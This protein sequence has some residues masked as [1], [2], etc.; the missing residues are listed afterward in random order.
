MYVLGITRC[1]MLRHGREATFI[2][3]LHLSDLRYVPAKT[4]PVCEGLETHEDDE[5]HG[6]QAAER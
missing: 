6:V 2:N 4:L 5:H 3:S 1:Y